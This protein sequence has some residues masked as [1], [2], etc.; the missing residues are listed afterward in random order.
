MWEISNSLSYKDIWETGGTP[1]GS[2]AHIS[3]EQA[4]R[5][6]AVMACVRILS[7]AIASLPLILYRR[8]GNAGKERATDLPLYH[9]MH[10]KPNSIQT[11]FQW[12]EMSEAHLT[13]RGNALSEVVRVGNQIRQIIPLNPNFTT[14][15]KNGVLLYRATTQMGQTSKPRLLT[16][17]EVLHIA[18]LTLKGV[19]G[20]SPIDFARKT[21]GL[22]SDAETYGAGQFKSGATQRLALKLPPG[23]KFDKEKRDELRDSFDKLYSGNS[24]T[25]VLLG[26]MD[27]TVIGLSAKDSQYLETREFQVQDIARIYRVPPHMIGELGKATFRNV[28]HLAQ[29]FIDYS[30]RPWLTRWEQAMNRDLLRNDPELFFE[31]FVEGLLRGDT[32]AR[33]DNY[34]KAL[35]NTNNGEPA[36]LTVE[37]VRVAENMDPIPKL[38]TLVSG[39]ENNDEETETE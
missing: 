19:K 1:P 26:G 33:S 9:L 36:W 8:T 23:E 28:E 29:Q 30:L 22:A 4:L 7:E 5:V 20:L 31:F 38:G 37:E 34:R 13:L 12:R 6:S 39:T 25:A 21:I 15:T 18:G 16:Q 2:T 17:R 14:E 35:G 27:A 10:D 24:K 3:D 11:S 32:K